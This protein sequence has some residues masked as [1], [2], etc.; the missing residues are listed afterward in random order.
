VVEEDGS[1]E[2]GVGWGGVGSAMGDAG[3][4]CA[5][6]APMRLSSEVLQSRGQRGARLATNSITRPMIRVGWTWY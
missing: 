4:S 1:S 3:R 2:S 5:W 6:E